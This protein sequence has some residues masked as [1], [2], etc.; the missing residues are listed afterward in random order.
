MHVQRAIGILQEHQFGAIA[1]VLRQRYADEPPSPDQPLTLVC[2]DT[3]PG[4]PN[5]SVLANDDALQLV[6]HAGGLSG[7]SRRVSGAWAADDPA[8]YLE[9]SG[10]A[11]MNGLRITKP[12]GDLGVSA[13]IHFGCKDNEVA[14]KA[15]TLVADRDRGIFEIAEEMDHELTWLEYVRIAGGQALMLDAGHIAS[16]SKVIEDYGAHGVDI[17]TLHGGELRG[18]S[19]V[20]NRSDRPVKAPPKRHTTEHDDRAIYVTDTRLVIPRLATAARR[21]LSARI[22]PTTVAA[23]DTV[24]K[25]TLV[26]MLDLPYVT[27]TQ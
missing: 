9:N 24:H 23:L 17:A 19:L 13:V 4:D 25:A 11:H 22:N 1:D 10:P 5:C 20:D 2:M 12:L 7:A 16:T 8:G 26:E 27:V 21:G 18:I 3:R 14:E 6:R 15:A